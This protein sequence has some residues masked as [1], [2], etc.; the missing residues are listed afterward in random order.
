MF[1]VPQHKVK[2]KHKLRKDSA[3]KVFLGFSD[4]WASCNPSQPRKGKQKACSGTCLRFG[5]RRFP[6]GR[7]PGH[8][9][10]GFPQW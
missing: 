10:P 9:V 8:C 3:R 5:C 4:A 1:A 2:T 6:G 7:T